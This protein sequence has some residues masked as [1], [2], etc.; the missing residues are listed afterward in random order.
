MRAPLL[1]HIVL[2][3]LALLV[4]S[5][6]TG[7]ESTPRIEDSVA[8]R[9]SRSVSSREQS[10]LSDIAPL[11]PAQWE[12]G[13]TY[14]VADS[15][16]SL[17]FLPPSDGTDTL[18]GHDIVYDGRRAATSLTG[19]DATDL[20]FHSTDG[21]RFV[22]RVPALDSLRFDTLAALDIPFTIDLDLVGRLDSRLRG[23]KLFIRT[24]AWY[25]ADGDRAASPTGLR[26]IEV[27]IDS[28]VP[29][30]ANFP[31]AVA[32]TV[33]DPELRQ[34]TGSRP[35]M[36]LMSVGSSKAASRNFDTLFSFDNPR[37]AYPTIEAATWELIM[38]SRVKAGMTREECRL[39]LGSP[40]EVLR[41]P[42]YGGM[43]ERWSYSDGVFLIFDD[44]LLSRY[45]L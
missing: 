38:A 34:R 17:I 13:R 2:A 9:T 37:K 20:T 30:T 19:E 1:R 44:G 35:H 41:T 28:V 11:P 7:I 3:T 18:V 33:V 36:V 16:I 40:T 14:R 10:F 12:P 21:R 45:R 42:S 39:A 27:N 31:A 24:P 4:S 22:Y 23:K 29:G 25:F 32:F 6:F 43:R 26:H 5:C 8:D 15:R